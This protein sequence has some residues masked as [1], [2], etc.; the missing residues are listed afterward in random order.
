M[1]STIQHLNNQG[2]VSCLHYHKCLHC[3]IWRIFLLTPPPPLLNPVFFFFWPP[4]KAKFFPWP[5]LK[6][7]QH[8]THP[9]IPDNKWTVPK[10]ALTGDYPFSTK[11]PKLHN[12]LMPLGTWQSDRLLHSFT[13]IKDNVLRL[14]KDKSVFHLALV[15]QT[16]DSTTQQINHYPADKYNL[17]KSIM[18]SAG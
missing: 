1:D 9:P 8:P 16:L 15:V 18:L 13:I 6:S 4:F 10:K 12:H 2:L 14:Q 11:T 3:K 5:T 17:R 7:P